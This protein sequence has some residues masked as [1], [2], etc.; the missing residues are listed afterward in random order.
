MTSLRSAA[1]TRRRFGAARSSSPRSPCGSRSAAR[2]FGSPSRAGIQTILE[3]HADVRDVQVAVQLALVGRY[4]ERIGDH[5]VNIGERVQYMVT[6]W[7]PEHAGVARLAAR[8]HA[9]P[10]GEIDG[11]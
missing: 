11:A 8:S 2:L 5:A 4:Y 7:L 9:D 1:P 10:S 3:V 6:G